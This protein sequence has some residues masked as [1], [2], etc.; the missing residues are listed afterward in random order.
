MAGM[1]RSPCSTQSRPCRQELEVIGIERGGEYQAIVRL[2]RENTE[3]SV[4]FIDEF[5]MPDDA[6]PKPWERRAEAEPTTTQSAA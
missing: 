2:R 3:G 6:D 5:V 1:S 4:V